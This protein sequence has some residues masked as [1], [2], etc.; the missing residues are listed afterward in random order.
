MGDSHKLSGSPFG[1]S[2]K[3]DPLSESKVES[4]LSTGGIRVVEEEP[5]M[6]V[7]CSVLLRIRPRCAEDSDNIEFHGACA[8]LVQRESLTRLPTPSTC[9]FLI[10]FQTL[11]RAGAVYSPVSCRARFGS[12]GITSIKNRRPLTSQMSDRIGT[13]RFS[14]RKLPSRRDR[15]APPGSVE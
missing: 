4:R 3:S 12:T 11:S 7:T 2:V 8:R 1:T 5:P 10:R 15:G 6:S 14:F 13:C 9:L